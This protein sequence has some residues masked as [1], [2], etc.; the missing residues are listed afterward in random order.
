MNSRIEFELNNLKSEEEIEAFIKSHCKWRDT[1]VFY[2]YFG[3]MVYGK[4]IDMSRV[5]TDSR[6]NKNYV[7][8][9]I[10]GKKLN[11]GRDKVIALCL[12]AHMTLEETNHSLE[13]C[14]HC[15]L[16]IE[17]ERDV[18]VAIFIK[19]KKYDVLEINLMLESK[20]LEPLDI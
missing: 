18:R 20:G 16:I 3:R 19:N 13:I 1:G 4:Q 5:I 8:N 11:P 9:I 2:K 6:I 17:S 12:G 10:N 14:G 15:R 7:Y